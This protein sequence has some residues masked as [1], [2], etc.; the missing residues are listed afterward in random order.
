MAPTKLWRL[1]AAI[2][3]WRALNGSST[4]ELDLPEVS[5]FDQIDPASWLALRRQLQKILKEN[6]TGRP[7]Y[8]LVIDCPGPAVKVRLIVSRHL[9]EDLKQEGSGGTDRDPG[10][11]SS[12]GSTP[13]GSPVAGP[14][15]ATASWGGQFRQHDK[16]NVLYQIANRPAGLRPSG[17]DDFAVF[18]D[19]HPQAA[20]HNL[21]VSKG[22][23]VSIEDLDDRLWEGLRQVLVREIAALTGAGRDIKKSVYRLIIN[24]GPGV[25]TIPQLHVHLLAELS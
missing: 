8:R 13:A 11:A 21:V 5:G 10:P 20:V 19:R 9:S 25:Q 24:T 3:G 22:E 23:H 1:L 6:Y 2:Q 14:N 12:P 15:P 7:S 4:W 18:P 17:N 16:S